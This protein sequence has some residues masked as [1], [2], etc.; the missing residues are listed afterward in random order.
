MYALIVRLP[1]AKYMRST[2]PAILIQPILEHDKILIPMVYV[3]EYGNSFKYRGVV[4]QST[5]LRDIRGAQGIDE[6]KL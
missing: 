4:L 2:L 5:L 6:F 1:S 3:E